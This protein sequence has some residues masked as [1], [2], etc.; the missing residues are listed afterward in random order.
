LLVL[1]AFAFV[2]IFD[3]GERGD[4]ETA[5]ECRFF[6]RALAVSF[7]GELEFIISNDNP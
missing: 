4:M 2:T 1:P 7:S 6:L 5:L 3:W